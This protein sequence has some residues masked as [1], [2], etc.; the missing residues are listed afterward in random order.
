MLRSEIANLT[1]ARYRI[2]CRAFFRSEGSRKMSFHRLIRIDKL[3]CLRAAMFAGILFCLHQHH[4]Q[5]LQSQSSSTDLRPLLPQVQEIIPEAVSLSQPIVSPVDSPEHSLSELQTRPVQATI[6]DEQ[7]EILGTVMQTSP[8][9]DRILGF[10]GPTNVLL[11]F[12]PQQQLRAVRI[13]FSRDTKEHAEQVRS[14][15][16][17]LTSMVG[18]TT[19]QLCDLHDVDAVSGAT[20]TSLA[21]LESIQLRMQQNESTFETPLRSRS[22]KFPDPPRLADVQIL[23]PN[24]ATIEPVAESDILWD[25]F[26]ADQKQVGRLLRT[27][28][29]GH[30][31]VGYQGPTD[32]L[33]AVDER[34]QVTGIAIGVSFD[35][36]PYVGYV[37]EDEY[38]RS[39]FNE[40]T[41][42]SLAE[43]QVEM[44]EGVS[45]ATMTSQ[46]V[47]R[48]LQLTAVARLAE[49][50][51]TSPRP[52][53]PK[54]DRSDGSVKSVGSTGTWLRNLS[55]IVMTGCGL[56]LGL[57]RLRGRR[58][59]RLSF[60]GLMIVWLGLINGDLVSQAFLLGAAQSGVPWRNALGLTLLT[61]A[62]LV[63]PLLTGRNVYCSHIC[64][65]GAVQQLVRRR[66]SWQL[67]LS[68]A[69]VRWV[70]MIPLVLIALV[71]ATG[72]WSLT[73]TAVD[74]EPFHAWLLGIAGV[75]SI[76]IA[77]VGLIASTVSPMAYCRLGCPTGAL[78]D[79]LSGSG[80]TRGMWNR[81][82]LAAAVL[83]GLAAISLW[84]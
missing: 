9:A 31:V 33:I 77:V 61:A 11:V 24:A 78:L 55:T 25:V 83:L 46:A 7:G 38:F 5:L 30:N 42:Q 41:L 4:I 57:T 64:P 58:W 53:T 19:E 36:E 22:L 10:S 81:Q 84:L 40:H 35:N 59:L 65:H 67:R 63:V 44:V 39:Y 70:K 47:A 45:G 28:P 29:A 48:S 21:I 16:A 68:P 13:L 32:S 82:D 2:T 62:A 3:R 20:L 56:V 6:I 8:V 60:Q 18:R 79:Y 23:Y 72:I 80:T 69:P 50:K 51:Q 54:T 75:A 74:L 26:N 66:L 14:D 52:D 17:F 49:L 1:K 27:S 34:D 76:S 73:F 12:D 71:I 43:L 37:Q 15:E